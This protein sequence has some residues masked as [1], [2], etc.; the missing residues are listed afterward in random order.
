[1]GQL[2]APRG[3]API[4]CD[5]VLRLPVLHCASSSHTMVVCFRSL[6]A[7]MAKLRALAFKL[8]VLA[9]IIAVL[10]VTAII[11]RGFV[12]ASRTIFDL[13]GENK[14]LKHA[15]AMSARVP[16]PCSMAMSPRW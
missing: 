5:P 11:G 2:A 10:V 7:P 6:E 14:E 1:M 3:V 13:L 15:I 8:V 12:F 4:W 16:R 9:V